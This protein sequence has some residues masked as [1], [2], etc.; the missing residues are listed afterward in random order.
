MTRTEAG[1]RPPQ[2][3][4]EFVRRGILA[5]PHADVP[6]LVYA[7]WLEEHDRAERAE[8]I[9]VQIELAHS[10]PS[11]ERYCDLV[12]R[13]T[14][15]EA[16]LADELAA[17]WPPLPEGWRR[18]PY[19]RGFPEEVIVH[20]QYVDT[21]TKGLGA[22]LRAAAHQM[23]LTQLDLASTPG[24]MWDVLDDPVCERLHG[25]HCSGDAEV[26]DR[27]CK[28]RY[29]GGLRHLAVS[30]RGGNSLLTRLLKAKN[31]PDLRSFRFT[32]FNLEKAERPLFAAANFR[33]QL[34]ALAAMH[35]CF[36][37][38]PSLA[39]SCAFPALRRFEYFGE[40]TTDLTALLNDEALY[41]VLD[42][43]EIEGASNPRGRPGRL[44]RP[45]RCVRRRS[46][47]GPVFFREFLTSPAL[48]TVRVLELEDSSVGAEKLHLLS[49][50][51]LFDGLRHLQIGH[52]LC[53]PD[54]LR[55]LAS[56]PFW[57]TVTSFHMLR[58]HG[59][60]KGTEW[61]AF[62]DA[63]N[64]P[65]LRQLTLV[66]TDLR[67]KGAL[68]LAKNRSFT[69]L[70]LLQIVGQLRK[71]AVRA[72]LTAPQF[73]NLLVLELSD[74]DGLEGFDVLTDPAVLPKARRIVL[75]EKI[76]PAIAEKLRARPG[77]VI[78]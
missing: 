7:D 44:D 1:V 33:E 36:G 75:R 76:P 63:W 21:T 40:F 51:G 67:S 24:P 74:T 4:A 25:L 71:Q 41:R 35:G 59:R 52:Q 60:S 46:H 8:F 5:N 20:G 54:G 9:R 43:V 18:G 3:D 78:R 6:R 61:V 55:A 56:A 48:R 53:T 31:L 23:P 47:S 42:T 12:E 57:P 2:T 27:L 62:F 29:L 15:L 14:E 65:A 17:E 64:A 38:Y 13:E 68:A 73:Q 34:V 45:L 50:P 77:V 32:F 69:G 22:Q 28:A 39:A 58:G 72:L 37:L 16:I 11:D 49:R 10:T 30:T 70:R 19:R 26:V 66:N